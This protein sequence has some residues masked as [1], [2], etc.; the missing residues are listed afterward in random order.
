MAATAA[1]AQG[2]S[3]KVLLQFEWGDARSLV[4]TK[5]LRERAASLTEEQAAK[6]REELVA[7]PLDVS[8]RL[9]LLFY[10]EPQIRKRRG[11]RHDPRPHGELILGLIENHPRSS[12]AGSAGLLLYSYKRDGMHTGPAWDEAIKLWKRLVAKHPKDPAI[13]AN[14]GLFLISDP[15]RMV[16]DGPLALVL[17]QRARD[18]APKESRWALSLGTY[19]FMQ[20]SMTQKAEARAAAAKPGRK[21]LRAA[22]DLAD[23][24]DRTRM[25]VMGQ[26]LSMVLATGYYDAGDIK[27]AR[28]F[29]IRALFI[30][31]PRK[32]DGQLVFEMNTILGRIALIEDDVE[33]ARR[34]LLAA[35]KTT[36]SPSL[37]SFGPDMTLAKELLAAGKRDV[38]VEFLE[39]CK[40]FWHS[41]K[42]QLES[43]LRSIRA[44]QNPWSERR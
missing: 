17:L 15:F 29:A 24:A 40:S 19:Y 30:E 28:T 34:Y 6:L 22:W 26:P 42:D 12:L 11:E 38:V 25:R 21:H 27:A 31:D 3:G 39:S 36:G 16:E 35:G 9:A 8:K 14:A 43:W 2:T 32:A 7:N 37:S 41:G 5:A 10:E 33:N 1:V 4:Q 18:L 13:A 44:G 20:L 23:A